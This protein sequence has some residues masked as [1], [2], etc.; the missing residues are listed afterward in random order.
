MFGLSVN[1]RY[2]ASSQLTGGKED[3]LGAPLE[4]VDSGNEKHKSV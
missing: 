4:M 3:Q 2:P 1:T